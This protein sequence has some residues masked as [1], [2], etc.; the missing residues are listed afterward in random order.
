MIDENFVQAAIKIKRQYL[1]LMNNMDM[2]RN[3]ARK[4]T[5]NLGGIVDKL[6]NI[7]NE[8]SK[9]KSDLTTESAIQEISKI[10]KDVDDEGKGL[11]ELV[12]PLNIEIEKL[13]IEEQELWRT[14]KEKHYN[15]PDDEIVEYVKKRLI[16][17]NLS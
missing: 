3:R 12:N 5:D 14:I 2:Y 1:K 6:E 13:A 15:I 4:M 11:E 9:E 7:Q 8:L 10:L 17:A 16:E